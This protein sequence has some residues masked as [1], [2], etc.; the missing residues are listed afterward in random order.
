MGSE[1]TPRVNAERVAL[2]DPSTGFTVIASPDFELVH[3]P[4]TG[5][6][7]LTSEERGLSFQYARLSGAP[8]PL[9]AALVAAAQTGLTVISQESNAGWARLETTS[10]DG[11]RS[12][13]QAQRDDM[14]TLKM[15]MCGRLAGVKR[16]PEQEIDDQL[17]LSI[18][19]A[20]ARGG[21]V[22]PAGPQ[23]T[24]Q[25]AEPAPAAAEPIPLEDYT[26]PD[27]QATGKVPDEP[28]WSVGGGGGMLY[29]GHPQRGE[30]WMG[31]SMRITIPGSQS[32]MAMRMFGVPAGTILA[33]LMS[34]EQALA[35]VW[36]PLRGKAEP[37]VE[38]G[39]LE[40]E[41]RQHVTSTQWGGSGVFTIR[42][43]RGGAP[44][45]GAVSVT[46]SQSAL[47]DHW[48][49][50][51]SSIL[52]PAGGDPRVWQMLLAAWAAFRPN[53]DEPAPVDDEIRRITRESQAEWFQ[54]LQDLHRMQQE[55]FQP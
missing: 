32:D 43:N 15:V 5:V 10:A 30:L 47:D 33:P 9:D 45:R 3:K 49:C 13:V 27:G 26:T 11:E 51:C 28:G 54:G 8:D 55:R 17:V 48:R 36:L 24:A 50:Y 46:T 38:F 4:E 2:Q 52:V 41:D 14:G 23:P 29:A 21:A 16:T 1:A 37:N 40:V 7:D 20:S 44:W 18:L 42:C 53:P 22:L 12:T 25:A 31:V 34:A 19:Y 6:Y 39:S 35:D